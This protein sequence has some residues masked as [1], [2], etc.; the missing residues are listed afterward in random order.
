MG[1]Q[2]ICLQAIRARISCQ[3]V[4]EWVGEEVLKEYRN[5]HHTCGLQGG[6]RNVSFLGQGSGEDAAM[7]PT[8]T[9]G[10]K[11]LHEDDEDDEPAETAVCAF[12]AGVYVTKPNE[13]LMVK[14]CGFTNTAAVTGTYTTTAV[15]YDPK[16]IGLEGFAPMR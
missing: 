6:D 2:T 4:L 14:P 11:G 7:D 10:G 13:K 9:G 3:D 5:L 12:N 15:E 8:D 16:E 1:G